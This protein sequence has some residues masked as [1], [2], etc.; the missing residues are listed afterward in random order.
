METDITDAWY[1]GQYYTPF[2]MREKLLTVVGNP[3]HIEKKEKITL[4]DIELLRNRYITEV[5][6][7]YKKWAPYYNVLWRKRKLIVK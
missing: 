7:L 3:I 4:V 6:R 2:P 1:F 5:K